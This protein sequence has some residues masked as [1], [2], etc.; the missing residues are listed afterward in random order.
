MS[1]VCISALLV[2]SLTSCVRQEVSLFTG[3]QH[4]QPRSAK[5]HLQRPL[6]ASEV[7]IMHEATV[8]HNA[9]IPAKHYNSPPLGKSFDTHVIHLIFGVSVIT[10]PLNKQA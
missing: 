9:A 5:I 2:T 4:C 3:K 6:H 10:P 8:S 1:Q 7:N